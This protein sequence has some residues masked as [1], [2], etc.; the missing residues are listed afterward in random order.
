MPL[1]I[2]SVD[3]VKQYR[4]GDTIVE[5]LRGVSVEVERGEFVV[6]MG[7]SGSGKSTLMHIL[8]CLDHPT[9]GELWIDGEDVNRMN[10]SRLAEMRNSHIGFVFQQFNL[11]ARTA[12]VSNVE[13]PLL[14]AG[15]S[16]SERKKR[17]QEALERVGL[18]HR[19]GHYPSQLSGGEQQRVAIARALINTPSI[20]MADEPTGNLDTKSGIEILA[21]LQKLNENGITLVMVTHESNLAEHGDRVVHLRD[22]LV[23]A[24]EKVENKGVA[25]GERLVPT[26]DEGLAR[27]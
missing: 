17:A 14:Y 21:I 11:L 22:G 10:G 25:A 9:S 16:S 6:I 3:L 20:L 27:P 7:S 2:K 19:M 23:R 24:E 18:S 15:V 13:L 1:I 26:G 8:G 4:M 5:A 12:A